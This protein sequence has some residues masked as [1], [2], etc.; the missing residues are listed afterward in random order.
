MR[1]YKRGKTWWVTYM[2]DGTRRRV[3][4]NTNRREEA[5]AYI[6][7]LQVEVF[8]GR[9]FPEKQNANITFE[10]M[11]ALWLTTCR[12]KK[13]KSLADDVSRYQTIVNFF[14]KS[15]LVQT[16]KPADIVRFVAWLQ[17]QKTRR[18]QPLA[19]ATINHHLKL[20]RAAINNA[21]ANEYKVG[22][23][24]KS[25]SLLPMYN[26]RDR[27]CQPFEYDLLKAHAYPKLRL[28]ICIAYWTGMRMNEIAM[29]NWSQIDL[30]AKQLR[31]DAAQTKTGKRRTVPLSPEVIEALSTW[32]ATPGSPRLLNVDK[33]TLSPAFTRLTRSLGLVDLRFHDL[34]HTAI[35][36]LRRAGVDIFTIAAI[37]GHRDLASLRRYNQVSD[38][39]KH[40][41]V[42]K[43]LSKPEPEASRLVGKVAP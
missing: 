24:A 16:T 37:S 33:R 9:H 26:E 41:A 15:R 18:G 5:Q 19:A 20:L 17:T 38:T 8:E 11:G 40:E 14:G 2:T 29:L 43:L 28:C 23:A 21:G 34:R 39:D 12:S 30:D 27:I 7:K 32:P 4:T 25:I 36:R 10:A 1:L 31:L 42:A 35:T 22:K 3:S 13:K 6:A